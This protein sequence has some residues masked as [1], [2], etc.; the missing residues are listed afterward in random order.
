MIA[1]CQIL[2]RFKR[3]IKQKTLSSMDLLN[4]IY[5]EGLENIFPQCVIAMRIFASM[6]VSVA[7]GERTFSK[8]NLIKNYLRSTMREERLNSLVLLSCER[9]LARKV[10][11]DGIIEAFAQRKARKI[12]MV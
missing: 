11:Y 4:R 3:T 6:P 7:E 9:D 5:A 10:N 8:L 12:K 1:E 2:G